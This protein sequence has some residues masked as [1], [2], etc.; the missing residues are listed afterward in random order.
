M[1][2]YCEK[3]DQDL[4]FYT[5]GMLS[6]VKELL[7]K[8][9]LRRCEGCAARTRDFAEASRSVCVALGGKPMPLAPR[10][11]SRLAVVLALLLLLAA[12]GY[13]AYSLFMPVDTGSC[14]PLL[15]DQLGAKRKA[16]RYVIPQ[17]QTEPR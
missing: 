8:W 5:Q 7:T 10:R 16:G 11:S 1:K 2:A 9:H 17:P 15:S 12:M 3:R 4:L 6:E 14:A 13:G